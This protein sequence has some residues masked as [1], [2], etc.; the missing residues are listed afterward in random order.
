MSPR[1]SFSCVALAAIG[2]TG[3]T[4]AAR[5]DE[6][7]CAE[8]FVVA[9]AVQTPDDARAF[10][11]CAHEYAMEMGEAE[12]YRAFHND[13]RWKSG[14]TYVFVIEAIPSSYESRFFVHPIRKDLEG[15]P[16][17]LL[18]DQFGGDYL[19]NGVQIVQ[20]YGSGFWYY[21]FADPATMIPAHKVA[22]IRAIDWNGNK[23]V[24]GSGVYPRDLPASCA[25]DTVNAAAL[26]SASSNQSLKEFVRCAA[27]IVEEKGYFGAGA[28]KDDPRW[29]NG[30][31][32]VF[33]LDAA[34]GQWLSGRRVAVNG[35][36]LHEWGELAAQFGG[37]DVMGVVDAFGEAYLYYRTMNPATGRIE[38]KVAFVKRVFA[39]G[40]P[41]FVGSGY[42]LDS[43]AGQAVDP[44]VPGIDIGGSRQ[45]GPQVRH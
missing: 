4:Q 26:A 22:F 9:P 35:V 33:G 44:G 10:V 14:S 13:E 16:F 11:N 5:A 39:Q 45:A 29:T 28:F 41:V 40:V 21:S 2:L 1:G 43:G 32:Y 17:G 20:N 15:R 19:A 37:R 6:L 7:P 24:I 12:A 23:A 31:A 25:A 42:Y 8:R 38:R 34:G 3:A 18:T 30:S 27:L 36:P